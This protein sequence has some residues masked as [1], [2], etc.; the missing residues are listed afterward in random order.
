VGEDFLIDPAKIETLITRRTK[1]ILPVHLF[2]KIC[3][4]AA[5]NKIAKRHGL[6]ILEDACQAHGAKYAGASLKN[7]KAFSFYPTKNLGAMGEGG[8]VVTNDEQ[9]YKFVVSFRNYGQAGRYNHVMKG[10]NFRLDPFKCALLNEKLKA[11]SRAVSIR[12]KL[13]LNYVKALSVVSGLAVDAYDAASC[14]HLFVIRALNGQRDQLRDYLKQNGIETLVHYPVS[15]YEQPCYRS[16]YP[17]LKLT[18]TDKFQSEILS[19]PCYPFL[20]TREQKFIIQKI[21]AFFK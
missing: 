9:I 2:G 4:M 14:Y 12:R 8:M 10:G 21:G 7:T 13:A 16:E 17:R 1:A 20:T 6:I 19:L 5:I 11:M 15:I 18:N 3:N